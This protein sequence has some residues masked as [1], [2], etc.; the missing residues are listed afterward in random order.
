MKE[1]FS[2]GE[3]GAY[4]YHGKEGGVIARTSSINQNPLTTLS[5]ILNQRFKESMSSLERQSLNPQQHHKHLSMMV[6]GASG[7]N[8]LRTAKTRIDMY[9]SINNES[10]L[11]SFNTKHKNGNY[12]ASA[13]SRSTSRDYRPTTAINYN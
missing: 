3:K 11:K 12:Q 6:T 13:T 4:E 9:R 5:M 10:L 7:I 2:S 1:P 8:D